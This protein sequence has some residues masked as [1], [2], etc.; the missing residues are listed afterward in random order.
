MQSICS[1]AVSSLFTSLHQ[2]VDASRPSWHKFQNSI[3]AEIRLLHSKPTMNSHFLTLNT[4][5]KVTPE[6][7]LQGS[8]QVTCST[9]LQYNK[10]E[11]TDRCA[12]R[13]YR[14]MMTVQ[15]NKSATFNVVMT[16]HLIF[17]TWETLNIEHPPSSNSAII[18]KCTHM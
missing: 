16:S 12:L 10:M 9:I 7:F 8:T 3:T 15:C 1:T 13:L 11:Q 4:A 5:D 18:T 14:K 2:H 6:V 17:M